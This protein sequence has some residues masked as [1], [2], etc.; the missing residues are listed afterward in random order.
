MTANQGGS[1]SQT[2]SHAIVASPFADARHLYLLGVG[3]LLG[4]LLGPAVLGRV[5]PETYAAWFTGAGEA[6]S[7]VR[8]FNEDT[9]DGLERLLATGVSGIAIEE[10]IAE[11]EAERQMLPAFGR[12][13]IEEK[14][15]EAAWAGRLVA[16]VLTI[17]VV[18]GVEA[19]AGP[20]PRKG[21]A[22][23]S[24]MLGRLVTI[25]YA[26]VALWLMLALASPAALLNAPWGFA[27]ALLLVALI[28]GLVPVGKKQ[29]TP[30]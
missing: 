24:P 11:R 2:S 9:A 30:A 17:I 19:W 25:R 4:I 21:R 27:A 7:E 28:V 12:A 3:L 20:T 18:M 15:H 29:S 1:I 22:V 6:A 14:Q 26:L 10:Y 23:V 13:V 16:L 5:A 8:V